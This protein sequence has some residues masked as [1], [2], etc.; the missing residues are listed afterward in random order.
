MW[1]GH[2]AKACTAPRSAKLRSGRARIRYSG[3]CCPQYR[4]DR[5]RD[6]EVSGG[7]IF[8]ENLN[9]AML[10]ITAPGPLSGTPGSIDS[11]RAN[12][13]CGEERQ[14]SFRYTMAKHV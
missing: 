11:T 10:T 1:D 9:W 14:A 13:G 6:G 12:A 8:V 5:Q 4:G 7:R 3:R 2:S